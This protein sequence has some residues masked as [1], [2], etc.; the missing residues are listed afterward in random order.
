MIALILLQTLLLNPV[1]GDFA[2]PFL[3]HDTHS[4]RVL[5]RVPKLFLQ[6]PQMLEKLR[7]QL[8]GSLQQFEDPMKLIDDQLQL[9]SFISRKSKLFS[10]GSIPADTTV[11]EVALGENRFLYT[12]VNSSSLLTV[13]AL[14]GGGFLL[15]AVALYLYDYFLLGGEYNRNDEK[16]ST[17]NGFYNSYGFDASRIKRRRYVPYTSR[18]D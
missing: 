11:G 16:V 4:P 14:V 6:D 1:F 2:K 17:Q 3:Y 7:E 18:M 8:D 10:S 15:V 9:S 13:S 5:P 12:Y